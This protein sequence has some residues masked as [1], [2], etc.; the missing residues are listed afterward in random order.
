MTTVRLSLGVILAVA[1]SV[2]PGSTANAD[3][4]K[5]NKPAKDKPVDSKPFANVEQLLA[6]MPKEKYPKSDDDAAPERR[7]ANAWLRE[8]ADGKTIEWSPTI[9]KVY[10]LDGPGELYSIRFT[11][12]TDT[13]IN[14]AK[15]A[16]VSWGTT[17]LTEETITAVLVN[18]DRDQKGISTAA[19]RVEL[20]CTADESTA[21]QVRMLKGKTVVV[22]MAISGRGTRFDVTNGQL[23]L[24]LEV[25]VCSVG[26]FKLD[27]SQERI[28]EA[29]K[30]P[31]GVGAR[32]AKSDAKAESSKKGR[33]KAEHQADEKP[34]RPATDKKKADETK[35]EADDVAKRNE[36][37]AETLLKFARQLVDA[38]DRDR[39][40]KQ[41]DAIIAKYPKTQ[42]AAE[43]KKLLKIL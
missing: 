12:A 34:A 11:F 32:D 31:D 18:F 30:L 4:D 21:K 14:P 17:K 16:I 3:A 9:E 24:F 35:S 19:G 28:S 8:H 36:Q 27:V 26:D 7:A 38:N 43:A 37:D 23:T 33:N 22:R 41:L 1:V 42:A 13:N 6:G 25:K 5:P 2:M 20:S 29:N 10:L 40:I 39:A 15:G